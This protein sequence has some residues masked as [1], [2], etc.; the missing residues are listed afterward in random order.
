MAKYDKF[1]QTICQ[2]QVSILRDTADNTDGKITGG[3]IIYHGRIPYRYTPKQ[4]AHLW[5]NSLTQEWFLE[6]CPSLG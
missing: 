1:L 2:D 6:S 5:A 3:G 4:T